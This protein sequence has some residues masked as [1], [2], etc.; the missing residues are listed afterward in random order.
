MKKNILAIAFVV[1]ACMSAAA[2]PVSSAQARQKAEIF[3]KSAGVT[4]EVRLT[5]ITS[6]TPFTEF[7][8]FT[9]GERGFIL[10]SGESRGESILGYSLENRFEVKD[11]PANIKSWLEGYEEEIRQMRAEG[12]PR[13][14][15]E[16]RVQ[17]MPTAQKGGGMAPQPGLTAVAPLMTT[18]WDQHPYYNSLCPEDADASERT[19]TGCVA[20]ATA[21]IMKYWNHPATGYG[22]HTYTDANYGTQSANFGT[23]TYAWTSMPNALGAGSTTAQVNAVATLMYHIGVADEMNYG[24]A[25]TGGSGAQNYNYTGDISASSQT[26][27]MKYFKYCPDMVT[28]AR[29]DYTNAQYTALLKAE[30]D[31][32]RPILYSG[33]DVGGGHSFVI[34]GYN[35]SD[36][37]H[38]NWGWGGYCDGYYA[39]GAL[40]PSGSGTGGNNGNYNGLNVALTN[41][42]P[43]ASF[44]TGGTVTATVS[45]TGGTVSGGGAYSFGDTVSL[46]ASASAGYRFAGWTDNEHFNPRELIGN[47]GNYSFAATFEPIAGDTLSYCGNGRYVTSYGMGASG[48]TCTWGIKLPASLLTAGHDM[49]GVEVYIPSAGT[50]TLTVYTGTSSPSTTQVNG[51]VTFD[52]SQAGSWQSLTFNT[53]VSIDGTQAVWIVFESGDVAF[54]AAFT[55]YSGRTEGALWGSSL[56]P[57]SGFSFMIRGIFGAGSVPVDP[58]DDCVVTTLPYTMGFESNEDLGCWTLR[59]ADGDG[60]NWGVAEAGALGTVAYSLSWDNTD[61]ALTPDNWL[62][63][64]GIALPAGQNIAMTWVDGSID[65]VYFQ[66]HYGVFVATTA[67]AEPSEYT[68][69]WHTTL[70]THTATTRT[71]D[72]SAYAGQTVYLAFRHYNSD[73]VHVFYIDNINVSVHVPT[74][75][76]VAVGGPATLEVG[77]QGTFR[78]TATNNATIAWTLQGATPAT[79]SGATATATW[80]AAGTYNV[81]AT[82]TNA[83]GTASDTLQVTINAVP[84]FT[85]TVESNDETMGT[86]L[87]GGTYNR[88]TQITLTAVPNTGYR[89][90]RWH[91]GMNEPERS[92]TVMANVTYSAYFAV[93][94]GIDDSD[95]QPQTPDFYPNPA[96]DIVSFS[97]VAG[98]KVQVIDMQ[99]R[100]VAKFETQNPKFEFD[101]RELTAGSYFVRITGSEGSSVKK[102]I[103]K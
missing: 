74:P 68:Q 85:I 101:V 3:L 1:F 102:L 84:T 18:T 5:D 60:N 77:Q 91:D 44:G 19:V 48:T 81:I 29:E 66:E 6:S 15:V 88:G 21:Q 70:T 26:S 49:R 64:P 80:A 72:L 95:L 73:D 32:S 98:K 20:T 23:T 28:L 33:R 103:V 83:D 52:E 7:Y 99:G 51:S 79:A 9:L 53:P 24:L 75:P 65:S 10:V 62:Y 100:E 67:D 30:L 36:Q 58:T 2:A 43:N 59:D 34:D 11:M 76:T 14:R 45:G 4:G 37:F 41:I 31:A 25:S 78:A 17:G 47:G 56:S 55:Y 92:L 94:V 63:M 71:L 27:L 57:F 82:A 97:G 61:G 42:R 69:L 46:M 13:A 8:V 22:S 12:Q 90:V 35:S 38:V 93:Q 40:N 87:G 50:Y 39:M 16:R 54:P 86:V 96:S 89:F